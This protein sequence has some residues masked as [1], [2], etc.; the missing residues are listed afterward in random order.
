MNAPIPDHSYRLDSRVWA[1]GI[2]GTGI[3]GWMLIVFSPFIGFAIHGKVEQQGLSFALF[4]LVVGLGLVVNSG[5]RVRRERNAI[6]PEIRA[7]A[8]QGVE[9]PPLPERLDAASLVYW[10][11][12]AKGP[13][14]LRAEGVDISQ[15]A[16]IRASW[17]ITMEQLPVAAISR[18]Q[19]FELDYV[20]H[21]PW[22]DIA[23][24]SVKEGDESPNY[25][26]LRYKNGEFVTI[27]RPHE[28]GLE[29]GVLDYVRSVGQCP[30]RLF[31]DV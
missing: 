21:L 13:V 2:K 16:L 26:E 22:S 14:Q 27:R 4:P 8:Y 28:R 25:Y 20:L 17:K 29:P 1:S 6:P 11:R 12:K 24:W 31:C 7:Q 9:F 15:V 23:E 18:Y 5:L 19:G 10:G 30:V 3:L